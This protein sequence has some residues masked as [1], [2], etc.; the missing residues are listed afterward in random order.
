MKTQ[1]PRTAI[2]PEL[3]WGA[4]FASSRDV[5]WHT[6]RE[7]ELVAVTRGRC[8]IRVGE[9]VW[10]G[11]R[12]SV[13]VLPAGQAQFQE[14]HGFTRTT[15]LGFTAPPGLFD[16]RVR[17]LRF[18]P[19]EPALGWIEQ[20]CDGHQ[21]H[22]A[23]SV[24]TSRVLLLALLRRIGDRDAASGAGSHLH[25]AI[26]A[27]IAHLQANLPHAHTLAGLA[28]AAGVSASHLGALFVQHCGTGPMRYL[29]RLRLE[30][31]CWL[32]AGPY[33]RIH[34]VA[35]ACGYEDVNYFTRLFHRRLGKS[36][37]RWRAEAQKGR[38]RLRDDRATARC[39]AKLG[40]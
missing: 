3:R 32:L 40:H 11:A 38:P 29:Q 9:G 4:R 16:E 12:G 14:T 20:L 30:R 35:A 23:F 6:H 19:S 31:A 33:L 27:A 10:E 21:N 7:T 8:R 25:P 13:F 22:P 24:S 37:G 28:R 18:E 5:P 17:V 15:Y 34:E 1:A 39:A 2:E 26:S 36:P